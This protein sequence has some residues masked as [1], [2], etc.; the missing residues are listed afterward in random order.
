M[1]YLNLL[2]RLSYRETGGQEADNFSNTIK[3]FT[4]AVTCSEEIVRYLKIYE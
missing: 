4:A 3:D 2:S 1:V